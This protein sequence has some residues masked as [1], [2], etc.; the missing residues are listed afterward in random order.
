MLVF[1]SKAS[2]AAAVSAAT[3]CLRQKKRDLDA[4]QKAAQSAAAAD[5]SSLSSSPTKEA[6]SL[7]LTARESLD[8]CRSCAFA[9]DDVDE[10]DPVRLLWVYESVNVV[11]RSVDAVARIFPIQT[12]FH[13]KSR[14]S[15][16]GWFS[17]SC[18]RIPHFQRM[19][20]VIKVVQPLF[21]GA[22]PPVD[23][24]LTWR[25]HVKFAHGLAADD[26]AELKVL[27]RRARERWHNRHG[28]DNT[29]ALILSICY[30]QLDR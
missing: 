9:E 13:L 24:A 20:T 1:L 4:K 28:I 26:A 29:P 17:V 22:A 25:Y 2:R 18:A 19:A 12:S 30:Q 27:A 5:S 6:Q 7:T 14:H 21:H 16:Y 8:A 23:Y 10:F 11:V 15:L 3:K